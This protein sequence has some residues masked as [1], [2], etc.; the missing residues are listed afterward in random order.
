MKRVYRLATV[1]LVAVTGALLSGCDKP[2]PQRP[3]YRTG[4]VQATDTTLLTLMAL[5][6]RLA[7]EA[8]R[9]VS[10]YIRSKAIDAYQLEC[11]AWSVRSQA[12]RHD[13]HD[14]TRAAEVV[15][16][17]LRLDST[18]MVQEDR[19]VRPNSEHLPMAVDEVIWGMRDGESRTLICPW[20]TAYGATGNDAVPPYT[21]C[22]IEIYVNR[23]L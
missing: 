8:D 11:G 18:L 7:A 12:E 3:S 10:A 17:I 1:A 5:N 22:I 9:Q 23:R 21:N 16:T 4:Q 15:L 14:D 19:L 6:E 20:Y 13:T 2:A